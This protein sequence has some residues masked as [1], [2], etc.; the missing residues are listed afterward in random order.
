MQADTGNNRSRAWNM[1]RLAKRRNLKSGERVNILT[2]ADWDES[3]EQ[4]PHWSFEY[5]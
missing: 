4:E 5:F 3:R 2:G 1:R